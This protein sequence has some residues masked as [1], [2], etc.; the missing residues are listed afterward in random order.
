M[1][2]SPKSFELAIEHGVAEITLDRPDRLN[3]LTFEVYGELADTFAALETDEVRSVIITGK[4]KGFC[5]GGDVEGIIAELFAA[6]RA[7]PSRLPGRYRERIGAGGACRI[8]CDYIAGMTDRFC[9]Q[10]HERVIG[11]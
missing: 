6:Y 8:I 5:S 7:D 11:A 1:S 3:A 2:L 4:G 9:R 10:E